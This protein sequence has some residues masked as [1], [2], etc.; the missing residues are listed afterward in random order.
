MV[1][2]GSTSLHVGDF[3]FFEETFNTLG[4]RGDNTAFILLDF[5][6]VDRGASRLDTHFSEVM[7][8]FMVLVGDVQQSFGGDA[9]DVEASSSE[10]ASFFDADGIESELCGLDG[11]DVS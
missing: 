1:N 5:G 11:S 10:R 4:E 2:K 6:P 7:V 3:V 8:E 9:T